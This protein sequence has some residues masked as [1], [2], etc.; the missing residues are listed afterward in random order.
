M[1]AFDGGQVTTWT[2]GDYDFAIRQFNPFLAMRVLG[3]LQKLLV[4]AIGGALDGANE[5]MT[6]IA[7]MG[8]AVGGALLKMAEIVDGDKLEKAAKLLLDSNY[9]SVSESGK[10]DFSRLDEGNVTA[11]FTGRPFDMI[12][13]CCKVFAVNFLDFS[14]SSSVPTGVRQFIDGIKEAFRGDSGTIS[15]E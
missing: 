2:Q 12:A 3:E 11:I 14:K 7:A 9:I 5:D 4:P 13:L 6:D 1:I 8:G 10:K 15:G